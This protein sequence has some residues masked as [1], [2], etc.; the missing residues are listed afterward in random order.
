M[1]RETGSQTDTLG[2]NGQS[3]VL[4]LV[5]LIGL[6]ATVSVGLLLIAGDAT[7]D[8]QQ[9]AETERVEQSFLEM[10]QNLETAS[11]ARDAA[12]KMNLDV[13]SGRNAVRYRDGGEIKIE[14]GTND[15]NPYTRDL[16]AI[17]YVTEDG[18]KIVYQGGGVWR[19]TDT[20]VTAI[21]K[22]NVRY[23]DGTL[24]VPV[25][26]VTSEQRLSG[27]TIRMEAGNTTRVHP[28]ALQEQVT[29]TI[30]SEYYEWWATHFEDD[31]S[32]GTVTTNE[33][34]ERVTVTIDPPTD[35]SLGVDANFNQALTIDGTLA[36]SSGGTT[37]GDIRATESVEVNTNVDGDVLSDGDVHVT[38]STRRVTGDIIAEGD[39]DID[40]DVR[41]DVIAGG[42][43][44]VA[45][46]AGTVSGNIVA[47]GD[48]TVGN[49]PSIGNDIYANGTIITGWNTV[50]GELYA[51]GSISAPGTPS[52][53]EHENVSNIDS[54]ISAAYGTGLDGLLSN[55]LGA[56]TDREPLDDAING[57]VSAAEAD[58]KTFQTVRSGDTLEAGTHY[59]DHI[60]ASSN[61][62]HNTVTFD[63]QDGDIN[64]IVRG[65]IS[66]AANGQIRVANA[67][68]GNVVRFYSAGDFSMRGGTSVCPTTGNR[69]PT[70]DRDAKVLQFY[71]TS[72]STYTFNGNSVFHGLIYAPSD[73]N[74]NVIA[75][76]GSIELFGSVIAGGFDTNGNTEVTYD[77]TLEDRY[78]EPTD[79]TTDD[80]SDDG[81][82]V[83]YL[84]ITVYELRVENE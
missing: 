42:N 71:G 20:G 48:V 43:V 53:A 81:P 83:N 40:S 45:S 66:V 8:V 78:E 49:G 61:G 77:D 28:G 74:D 4:G 73:D 47:G 54:P 36:T 29:I 19:Q 60:D 69:C 70:S 14:I 2:E 6:V 62:P 80:A 27:G 37:T 11:S 44:T 39:V 58:G 64:V 33:S 18:T 55:R 15:S 26:R 17:E 56:G 21:S 75:G 32:I 63:V 9:Q 46:S 34:A 10:S 57:M 72:E 52:S 24:N 82:I 67:D 23:T 25:P 38:S 1:V 51:T 16:G 79:P 22:P 30:T 35:P 31:L 41:G 50:G 84:N 12:R 65:D 7:T 13:D 3:A 68:S 76:G 59:V 5:L